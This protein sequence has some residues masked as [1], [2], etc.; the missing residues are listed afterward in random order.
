MG[1]GLGWPPTLNGC[2]KRASGIKYRYFVYNNILTFLNRFEKY[3]YAMALNIG[4]G[5]P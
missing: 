2:E 3:Y 1:E 4:M 5:Y